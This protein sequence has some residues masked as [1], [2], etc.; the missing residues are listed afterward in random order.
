[1]KADTPITFAAAKY[2]NRGH[3][4]EDWQAIKDSQRFGDV[5]HMA[6]AV[7]SKGSDG[8][9]QVEPHDPTA[10]HLPWVGA[11]LLVV[12]ASELLE[13]GEV[14]LVVVA[15]NRRGTEVERLLVNVEKLVVVET[16]AGDLDA[17]TEKELAKANA[18]V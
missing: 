7:L 5:E 13:R 1:M 3:A 17:V 16:V 10:E 8:M 14:G 15:V 2:V 12:E 4:L 9:L 18:G 6:V 11:A